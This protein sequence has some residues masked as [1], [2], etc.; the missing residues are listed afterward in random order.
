AYP[1]LYAGGAVVIDRWL[2][3]LRPWLQHATATLL[4]AGIAANVLVVVV[5]VLPIA[6]INSRWW[7]AATKVNG[8]LVEE[9]GWPDLVDTVAQV[10]DSLPA[11]DRGHVGILAGN[12]GEAG[13]INLYGPEHGLAPAISGM[14]SY[15]AR[16][17][18]NPPPEVLIVL[19]HSREFVERHFESC[20]TVGRV[21]N[22]HGVANEE[23]TRRPEIFVCRRLRQPWPEFWKEYRHYG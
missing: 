7:N 13:A 17:Y 21:S 2:L 16:G 5:F 19:G 15:W 23:S 1:V 14:N 22:R 8:D 18:G 10:R 9:I 11:N 6:P 12:Y 20:E 3:N 4:F